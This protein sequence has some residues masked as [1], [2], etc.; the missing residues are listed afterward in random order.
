L[1]LMT[2]PLK[3]FVSWASR[4]E[5][6]KFTFCLSSAGPSSFSFFF[7]S[8]SSHISFVPHFCFPSPCSFLLAS[9]ALISCDC[10]DEPGSSFTSRL[11]SLLDR[12]YPSPR[13][14]RAGELRRSL[15]LDRSLLSLSPPLSLLGDRSRRGERSL[16]G[17][18]ERRGGELRSR[19]GGE[20][21]NRS[22]RLLSSLSRS[23]L[24]SRR[25][26][27]RRSSRNRDGGEAF[28]LLDGDE[29]ILAF[30]EGTASLELLLLA[31]SE[32]EAEDEESRRFRAGGDSERAI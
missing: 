26:E 1:Y 23:L 29:D 2:T 7:L 11:T 22:S 14:L 15:S 17:D 6:P 4:P 12:P 27:R 5:V 13:S 21:T 32:P 3:V 24:S 18:L 28:R 19:R 31:E 20:S 8:S 16:L 30:F 10:C 9:L 25:G